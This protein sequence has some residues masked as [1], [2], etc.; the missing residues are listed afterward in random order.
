MFRLILM[1]PLVCWF[2]AVRVPRNRWRVGVVLAGL[3]VAQLAVSFA[4]WRLRHWQES[5]EVLLFSVS[6]VVLLAALVWDWAET[7]GGGVLHWGVRGFAGLFA[8]VS[9][10]GVLFVMAVDSGELDGPGGNG[11]KV[12]T[13]PDVE[14]LLP[15]PAGLKVVGDSTDCNRTTWGSYC[16][17]SFAIAVTDGSPGSEVADRLLRHLRDT[18]GWTFKPEGD[19]G[20]GEPRGTRWGACRTAGWWLDRQNEDVSVFAFAPG[21]PHDRYAPPQ[22]AAIVEFGFSHQGCA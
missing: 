3:A 17:R 22:A 10:V 11:G 12:V 19:Y 5:L 2:L 9:V 21:A 8:A 7:G 15:L 13:T 18:G 20:T 14:L 1:V 16:N 6:V 4:E